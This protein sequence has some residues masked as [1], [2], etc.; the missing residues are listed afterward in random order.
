M[1]QP[2][3]ERL[4]EHTIRRLSNCKGHLSVDPTPAGTL[5]RKYTALVRTSRNIGMKARAAYGM[6]NDRTHSG[7]QSEFVRSGYAHEFSQFVSCAMNAAL[8]GSHGALSD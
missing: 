7:I 3:S 1:R 8:D 6:R 4:A 2:T 5:H